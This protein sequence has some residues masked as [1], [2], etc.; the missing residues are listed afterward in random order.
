[1][2]YSSEIIGNKI[3]E[4]RSNKK[5]SQEALGNKIGVSG[6][7]VSNYEKAIQTPPIDILFKLCE[8]FDCEL[9]FLLGEEKYESG[10]IL[11]TAIQNKLKLSQEAISSLC[12]LT[13][14]ESSS[15]YRGYKSKSFQKILNSFLCS[16]FFSALICSVCDLDNAIQN[17]KN[18]W[19]KLYNKYGKEKM[20]QAFKYYNSTTDYLLDD[21]AEK[22]DDIYY[23]ILV[24]IDSAIDKE[25]DASYPIKVLRYEAREAFERLLDALYPQ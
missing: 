22:L 11:D 14:N 6:K 3:K 24:A 15:I 18:I 13:G 23:E 10:T 21:T 12:H 7:Q 8:I 20:H 9:G 5:W 25:H 16:D 17:S 1:M 19:D 2:N 4:Q